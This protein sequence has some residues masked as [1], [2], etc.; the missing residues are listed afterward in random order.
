MR[1]DGT[2]Q[3]Q[4]PP[5]D[6]YGKAV[7]DAIKNGFQP[8]REVWIVATRH[9][10]MHFRPGRPPLSVPMNGNDCPPTPLEERRLREARARPWVEAEPPLLRQPGEPGAQPADGPE[11]PLLER[12]K[13]DRTEC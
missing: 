5:F 8:R 3:T 9:S 11:P 6:S 12:R 10:V 1:V 7:I 4:S 2:I 13:T